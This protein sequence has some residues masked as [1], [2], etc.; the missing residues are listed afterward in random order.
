M[1]KKS[2]VLCPEGGEAMMRMWFKPGRGQPARPQNWVYYCKEHKVAVLFDV[3]W[4]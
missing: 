3:K 2:D 1:P 4:Y